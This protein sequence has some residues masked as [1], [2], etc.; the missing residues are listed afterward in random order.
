MRA[1]YVLSHHLLL[2]TWFQSLLDSGA[3]EFLG[4]YGSDIKFF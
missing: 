4:G 3:D 1:Q 2:V